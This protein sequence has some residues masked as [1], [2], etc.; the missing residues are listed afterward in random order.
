M[1][2][3]L[4][5]AYNATEIIA[6]A[7]RP[8]IRLFTVAKQGAPSPLPDLLNTTSDAGNPT[9]RPSTS[10]LAVQFS[11]VCYLTALELQRLH[12]A[13]DADAVYGLIDS[14]VGSTDVQSWMSTESRATALHTCW[15]PKNATSLPPSHSHSPIGQTASGELWNAMIHPLVPFGLSAVL[16]DQGE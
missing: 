2:I 6:A 8:E 7:N 4:S 15:S 5:A 11:A 13:G 10:S 9:W 16:W 14:A 1:A 12:H 3:A